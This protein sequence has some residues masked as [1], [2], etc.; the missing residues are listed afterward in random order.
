MKKTTML[1]FAILLLGV[2]LLLAS[3]KNP[4]VPESDVQKDRSGVAVII[5]GAA[6]RIPQEAALLEELDNRGL[7]KD[8]VFISGVSSGALNSVMLNGILSGKIT[9]DEYK[10]ILYNL[11]NSDIFIQNGKKIPVNTKPAREL[12]SKVVEDMLGF[13]TIGDLPFMTA[14]S[15]TH[16]EDLFMKKEVYRMCSHKINGETDTTL[17]LVDIM[18]ASSAFPIVFPPVRIK[19]ATTIPDVEYVD[20]GVGNDHVPYHAL[21]EFE[22]FRGFGV[23]KVYIISRS[24]DSVPDMSEELKGFGINDNGLFDKMNISIDDILK[25]GILK[26]LTEFSKTAPDLAERTYVWIPNLNK[27]FM[28]FNFENMKEQYDLTSQ[29]AK[30]NDPVRLDVFLYE[31]YLEEE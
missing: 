16:P 17:N 2:L 29:W 21:L 13:K 5:T 23:E 7:L 11:K 25:K 31:K 20:G 12:Y 10:N 24:S 9:W 3:L 27:N 28:L 22:K 30:T 6:A 8:L 1:P 19:N 14:I 18:M 4:D 26:C 15:F